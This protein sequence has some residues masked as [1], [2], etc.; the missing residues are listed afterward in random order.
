MDPDIAFSGSTGWDFLMASRSHIGDSHQAD[1]HYPGTPSSSSL[2]SA[3]MH[4]HLSTTYSLIMVAPLSV[5]VH[6][7]W[8]CMSLWVSF[9]PPS[10]LGDG[11]NSEGWLLQCACPPSLWFLTVFPSHFPQWS[12]G[13]SAE[14]DLYFYQFWLS[15]TTLHF[16][17]L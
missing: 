13:Y 3:H 2:Y 1:Y 9:E 15:L 17:Q 4:S 8:Q 11:C 14:G 16:D 5:F 10:V 7:V 12:I 6:A